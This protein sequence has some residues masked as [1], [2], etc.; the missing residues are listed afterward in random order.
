[1]KTIALSLQQ[2]W[3]TLLVHGHKTVEVRAWPTPRRGPVLIH[4]ARVPDPRPE[5]WK[6]LPA[7]LQEH[8]KLGGGIVGSAELIDCIS[9]RTLVAFQAHQ[10]LHLNLPDWYQ[11]KLF[12]FVFRDA[13]PLPFRQFPGWMRFFE[14]PPH[15]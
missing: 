1:M 3:A 15:T 2:P 11:Q 10:H 8:A 6:L 4:A 7:E 12:G 13:K 9:Y 5:A 14:V